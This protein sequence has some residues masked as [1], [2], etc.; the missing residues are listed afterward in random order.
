MQ[1][2]DDA[3]RDFQRRVNKLLLVPLNASQSARAS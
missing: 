3:F 1:S 2:R